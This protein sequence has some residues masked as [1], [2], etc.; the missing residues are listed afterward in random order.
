MTPTQ[1]KQRI[2]VAI[3]LAAAI[4]IPA[5]G[6]RTAAYKDPVGI[7]TICYGSTT[8]V[9]MGD[10]KDVDQCMALLS[11]EMGDA[12]RQVDACQ[13]GLPVGVLAAFSDAAYNIGPRIACDTR[14]STA[15][16]KLK[17]G[18]IKGACLELPKWD[19]AR[20]AGVLV[21]LPGLTKRRAREME[22]CLKDV[23]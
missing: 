12:V 20:V 10:R 23:A 13:P 9:R 1:N 15:A 4:A 19:K 21:P 2:G 6:L 8:G 3:T 18:D 14:Q 11:K 16:R 7:T 22:I 17:A 5:E